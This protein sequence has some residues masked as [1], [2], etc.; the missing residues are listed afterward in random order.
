MKFP[1]GQTQIAG[2]LI[3]TAGVQDFPGEKAGEHSPVDEVPIVVS[4]NIP[5]VTGKLPGPEN[6][7]GT[8][9]ACIVMGPEHF[10]VIGI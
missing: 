3:I 1:G 10:T 2:S 7:S 8:P 5:L 9:S 4:N 6:H